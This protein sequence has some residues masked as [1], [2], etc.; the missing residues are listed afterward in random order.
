[1]ASTKNSGIVDGENTG[2][3]MGLGYNDANPPTNQGG[4]EITNGDDIIY[5]NGGDDTIDGAG[6]DDAIFGDTPKGAS[7]SGGVPGDDVIHAMTRSAAEP[8]TTRSTAM[9]ATTS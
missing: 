6:G 7:G 8:A 9:P 4:D 3:N 2:E 1:M 5:G